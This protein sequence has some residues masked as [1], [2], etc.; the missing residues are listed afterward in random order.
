M[1]GISDLIYYQKN[2]DLVLSKKKDHYENNKKR[3]REQARD[4]Y[5]SLSEEEK[6]KKSEYR[7]NRYHNMPEEEKRRLKEYQKNY[8]EAKK[9]ILKKKLLSI[10]LKTKKL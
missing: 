4:R 10:M 8:L 1:S 7:K 6:S 2:R 3:L 5:K 9:I